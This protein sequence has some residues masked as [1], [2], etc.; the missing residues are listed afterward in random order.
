MNGTGQNNQYFTLERI[1]NDC[2]Q[3]F[4]EFYNKKS[5]LDQWFLS[6]RWL[7]LIWPIKHAFSTYILHFCICQFVFPFLISSC[8]HICYQHNRSQEGEKKVENM[9]SMVIKISYPFTLNHSKSPK[10]NKLHHKSRWIHLQLLSWYWWRAT[11]LLFCFIEWAHVE[12][13]TKRMKRIETNRTIESS[14]SACKSGK[15]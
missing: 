6:I 13:V 7:F 12:K 5:H 11:I 1:G 2:W 10:P 14:R 15:Q 4:R 3:C 8:V 9:A